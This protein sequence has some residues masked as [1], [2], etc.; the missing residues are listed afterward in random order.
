MHA[1]LVSSLYDFVIH[2]QTKKFKKTKIKVILLQPKACW[3]DRIKCCHIHGGQRTEK[4]SDFQ[5]PTVARQ[6]MTA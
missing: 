6:P 4:T 2:T 3:T 5:H 1:W